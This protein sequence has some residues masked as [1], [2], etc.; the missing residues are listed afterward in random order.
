MGEL[1]LIELETLR[2]STSLAWLSIDN[3]DSWDLGELSKDDFVVVLDH[4]H[5]TIGQ[6]I[7]VSLIIFTLMKSYVK[8]H[9]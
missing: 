9:W 7:S 3:E 1:S 4:T 5:D 6:E 8:F 2:V